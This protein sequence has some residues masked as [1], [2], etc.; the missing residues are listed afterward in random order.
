MTEDDL[1][2]DEKEEMIYFHTKSNPGLKTH[3]FTS[4]SDFARKIFG[5]FEDGEDKFF[6]YK[7]IQ[8]EWV[9]VV[10]ENARRNL[11]Y[12]DGM[13]FWMLNDCWPAFGG[14]SFIDYYCMPKQAFYGFKRLSRSV[15]GSV[16]RTEN[17]Y[18]LYVSN[19]A[20][21]AI[22]VSITAR[23]YSIKDDMALTNTYRAH[24]IS[25]AYSV[26]NVELPFETSEDTVVICDLE[27]AGGKDRC[28]YKDG[29]LALVC[30]DD[31]VRVVERTEN[32]ITLTADAYVHALEL[33]GEYMLEDNCFSMLGG[34]TRTISFKPLGDD[35]SQ[36]L[37]KAYTLR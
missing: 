30:A 35:N 12:C 15:I 1:L 37:I 20:D 22:P 10:F 31:R 7:Y 14:W 27:Y 25:G 23:A 2:R 34:E 26:K 32:S 13:I 33:E 16:V 19:D 4:V 6:K 28:F 24:V 17:G 36:L 29:D 9:R 5:E 8:Y 18:R 11:G 3:L 21:K